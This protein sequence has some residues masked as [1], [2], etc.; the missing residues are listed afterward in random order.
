MIGNK[1]KGINT[2]WTT[3]RNALINYARE[4][5]IN[6]AKINFGYKCLFPI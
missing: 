2:T 3:G 1:L 5:E 4:N 6:I